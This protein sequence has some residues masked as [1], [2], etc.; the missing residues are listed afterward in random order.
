[1]KLLKRNTQTVWYQNPGNYYPQEDE[2]GYYTGENVMN[3]STPQALTCT[4][5]DA[6]ER[7]TLELFGANEFYD[8]ILLY[9]DKSV[10]IKE[11]SLLFI[12]TSPE[13]PGELPDY[14]VIS[15]RRTLNFIAIGV[16]K[17]G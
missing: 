9:D 8:R 2:N 13:R 15:I 5:I 10:N 12:D 6:T 14:K 1:M 16:R 7:T 4:V 11:T 17:V 3:Y